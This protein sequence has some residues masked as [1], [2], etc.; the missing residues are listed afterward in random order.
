MAAARS[1][2]GRFF[3]F[4]GIDG[5]GKTTQLKLFAS[6]LRRRKLPVVITREPGGTVLGESVRRILLSGQSRHMDARTE[7]L[8]MF[9]AR[10]QHVAQVIAPALAQGKIVLSDRFADASLAY[11]GYGRR[12]D[13][14]FIQ[15]LARFACRGLK[16]DLTF[17]LDIAPRTSLQRARRRIRESASDEGRFEQETLRFYERVRRGYLELARREP[18]RIRRLDGEDTIENIHQKIVALARPLATAGERARPRLGL[19]KRS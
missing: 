2:R 18:G 17:M 10:A 5:C 15:A 13:R 7:L 11:Q 14:R 8:L 4:E 16:P 19:A 6:Y 3:T 9:A 12:L 1:R